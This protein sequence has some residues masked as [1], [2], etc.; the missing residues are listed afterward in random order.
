MLASLAHQQEGD[1]EASRQNTTRHSGREGR[2]PERPRHQPPHKACPPSLY[3]R[4]NSGDPFEVP[5][6]DLGDEAQY[7]IVNNVT[8]SPFLRQL[9]RSFTTRNEK[10]QI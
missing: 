7:L 10:Q 4:F 6:E 8:V 2:H 1:L 5:S 3:F 9:V